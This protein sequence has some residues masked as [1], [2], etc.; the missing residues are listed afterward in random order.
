MTE[1]REARTFLSN[2]GW[3]SEAPV[4]LRTILLSQCELRKLSR[5][6]YAYQ[7]GDQVNGLWGVVSGG[8]AFSIAP[9]EQGPH[10]A[11]VFRPGFWFG[12]AE[13]LAG[14]SRRYDVRATREAHCLW[15]SVEKLSMVLKREPRLWQL[16]GS[17]CADHLFLAIGALDDLTIRNSRARIAAILLRLANVRLQDQPTDPTPELDIKQEDL[18]SLANLPRTSVTAYLGEL[19]GQDLIQRSYGAVRIINPGGLRSLV[20]EEAATAK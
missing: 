7:A 17:L 8:F 2:H 20:K 4:G 14:T 11:H 13:F 16:L 19:E 18:G 9:H 1:L 5:G 6:D 15:L 12:E 3:L 10:M